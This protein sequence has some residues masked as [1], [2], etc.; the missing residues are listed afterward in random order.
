[1]TTP[2]PTHPVSAPQAHPAES[3]AGADEA[4]SSGAPGQTPSAAAP[5][6]SLGR[7]ARVAFQLLGFAIGIALLAWCFQA[8]LGSPE[9][10]EQLARAA[11]APPWKLALLLL[12]S[13]LTVG[14]DGMFFRAILAPVRRLSVGTMLGI[15]GIC[16][17]LSYLPFKIGM[18]FRFL[19]HTRRNGMTAADVLAWI[20]ATG[21]VLLSS[22]GPVVA[23]TVAWGALARRAAA[24][25]APGANATDPGPWTI[26]GL[27]WWVAVIGGMLACAAAAHIGGRIVVSASWVP[28]LVARLP[29]AG[30]LRRVMQAF[31]M[32]ASP[33]AVISGMAYRSAIIALQ[34]ARFLLAAHLVEADVSL[35]QALIAGGA[36][37][38]IQAVSPGGV[39][40][41]REAGTSA[42][43]G[44]EVL[45]VTLTV[46][47]AEATANL[48]MA[49]AGAIGL[50]VDRLM[51]EGRKK[52]D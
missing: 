40:G 32:L 52:E 11:H 46:S 28:P 37:N 18:L 14:L 41:F 19:Y 23:V 4:G 21:I 45:A 15:S 33:R 47:A 9:R 7:A 12:I 29:A 10:R 44:P 39:S 22:L 16:S 34:A 26:G 35:A 5:R 51:I 48:L 38:L 43:L 49:I 2:D 27:N 42:M 17:A 31:T 50:R 3:M 8:A 36:Y 6:S 24:N 25:G 30:F 1:M 20:G 13:A